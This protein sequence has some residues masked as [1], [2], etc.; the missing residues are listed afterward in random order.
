MPDRLNNKKRNLDRVRSAVSDPR[1]VTTASA[2]GIVSFRLSP[3]AGGI[4]V[5][6]T[7]AHTRGRRLVQS[8]QFSDDASFLRWCD[9][10]R[11]KFDYPLLYANLR[12][13]GCALFES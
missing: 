4:L 3:C 1:T 10:D 8:V 5:M 11:L 12:R 2:D 6:R 13:S 7:Q 9:T